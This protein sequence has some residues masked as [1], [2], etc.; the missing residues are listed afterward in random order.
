VIQGWDKGVVGQNVGSRIELEIP[1]AQ[2]YGAQPPQGSGIPANASLVFVV[3]I[4]DAG[5]GS[6]PQG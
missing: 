6:A 4:L 2:A 1:A 3:D 5:V